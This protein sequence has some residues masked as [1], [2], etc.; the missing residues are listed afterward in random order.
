MKLAELLDIKLPK[1]K[2]SGLPLKGGGTAD[3]VFSFSFEEDDEEDQWCITGCCN[4]DGTDYTSRSPLNEDIIKDI[5][6]DVMSVDEFCQSSRFQGIIIGISEMILSTIEDI[7]IKSISSEKLHNARVIEE[8][9]P[10]V[11]SRRAKRVKADIARVIL[12]TAFG[13]GNRLDDVPI[14][15]RITPPK[16]IVPDE[17]I[18]S[19][20]FRYIA[21]GAPAVALVG[22]TGVGK[23][24]TAQ[25]IGALLNRKGY[26]VMRIDANARTEGDRLFDRDDFNEKGT[27]ILEGTLT[28]F[29]R[30][31]K[32]LGLK[33]LVIIEEYNAFDDATR[34]EFYQL[35]NDEERYYT[36]QSSKDQKVLD[37]VD[38]H[39]VQ[40][41]LTGNP[42]TSEKYLVDDLKRFSNAEARRII[43]VYQ[44]YSQDPK[45][46]KK[47]LMAIIQK[48]PVYKEI[49]KR[50]KEVDS[51]I[52]LNL[53]VRC[54]REL[55]K[56]NGDGYRL[57]FDF[58]YSS[59]ANWLWT[60]TVYGYSNEGWIRATA[61]HLL[62][63]IPDVQIREDVVKRLGNA[64]G[65]HLPSY[66]IYRDS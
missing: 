64:F 18:I 26:A 29:A 12:E 42:I 50:V 7:D 36:I 30:R 58:G 62:N 39:H 14:E 32:D 56:P 9:I 24:Y 60:L 34:R 35:F 66:L 57:G 2:Y 5:E 6:S 27:F 31:T 20:T 63:P 49:K 13:K 17:V 46:I 53:G 21:E 1:I 37:K 51:L 61:D 59:I 3:L 44:D 23:S 41:L 10:Q 54:F 52:D 65:V 25:H 47:V 43:M 15:Y 55:N 45:Y 38:F 22:P 4:F 16:A 48:K 28:T 8:Y 11:I 33:G 19:A 40:F